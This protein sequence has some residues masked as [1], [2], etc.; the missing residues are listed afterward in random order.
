MKIM[1]ELLQKLLEADVL[2]A[3]TKKELENA[4]QTQLDEAI[5]AAR[6]EAAANIR[7]ELAEQWVKERD[8]L[9][10][11]LD[12]KVTEFLEAEIVELKEDIE[13]FRDLEAEYAERLVEAKAQMADELKNDLGELVEKLD[14]FL[15]IRLAAEV[16]ELREDLEEVRRNDFGRRIFEAFAEEYLTNY[17]DEETAEVSLRE[18][19]ERLADAE[20]A[21]DRAERERAT[22]ERKIKMEQVLEPL[23]GRSRD[24]MEAILKNVDTESL[25]EAYKTFIGRV[26]READETSEKEN[27]VLAESTTDV[28]EDVKKGYV[29]TGDTDPLT[30]EEGEK[31]KANIERLRRLAGIN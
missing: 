28:K 20:E 8:A 29:A 15:E 3:E 22:L 14:T 30:L 7:V 27:K 23:A 11:A 10:V 21:L 25:D 19:Q 12:E 9:V 16:E 31:T 1:N 4:F 5:A 26:L 17:V 18:M 13:R 24:V 2:S 6:D